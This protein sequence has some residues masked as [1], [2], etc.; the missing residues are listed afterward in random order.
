MVGFSAYG[1]KAAQDA[2]ARQL[3]S[4]LRTGSVAFIV[5]SLVTTWFVPTTSGA[6]P[7]VMCHF[8]LILAVYLT[9]LVAVERRLAVETESPPVPQE[10]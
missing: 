9:R 5:P 4:H 1:A 3:F 7:S 6:L 10:G 2:D 8:A